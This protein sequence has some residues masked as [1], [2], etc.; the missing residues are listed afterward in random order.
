[1][2]YDFFYSPLTYVQ[3][4]SKCCFRVDNQSRVIPQSMISYAIC[5]VI[6]VFVSITAA[7]FLLFYLP[8]KYNNNAMINM[9]A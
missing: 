5:F 8:E 7:G 9:T 1:M 3:N 4:N 6:P 2:L